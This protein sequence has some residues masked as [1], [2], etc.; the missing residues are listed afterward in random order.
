MVERP[1]SVTSNLD[2][3]LQSFLRSPLERYLQGRPQ[4]WVIGPESVRACLRADGALGWS[5][6]FEERPESQRSGPIYV[7]AESLAEEQAITGQLRL[8]GLLAYG[9]YAWLL[10]HLIASEGYGGLS[11]PGQWRPSP[12]GA[13]PHT[14]YAVLCAPRTGSAYLSSLLAEAGLGHPVEHV[15]GL[16]I[17]A[18]AAAGMPLERFLREVELCDNVGGVFGTKLVFEEFLQAC[19]SD[20]ERARRQVEALRAAGYV[21]FHLHRGVADSVLS[22]V[23][24]LSSGIWHVGARQLGRARA[25]HTMAEPDLDLAQRLVVRRLAQDALLERAAAVPPGCRVDY[26]HLVASPD[27]V[28]EAVLDRLSLPR[29]PQATPLRRPVRLAADNEAYARWG[30]RLGERLLREGEALLPQVRRAAAEAGGLHERD[31]AAW[32]EIETGVR[33]LL[34]DA[35]RGV[36]RGGSA[37]GS[38]PSYSAA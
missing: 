15:R 32:P 3:I 33:R 36:S 13:A 27:A 25:A 18:L 24:A 8:C 22:A 14:R 1:V 16:I 23:L 26:E 19:F 20:V 38:E 17:Q 6:T 2:T 31:L 12:P 5:R 28:V 37:A 10:P 11:A 21:F 35:A 7:F 4:G 29:R 30:P 9:F 34:D